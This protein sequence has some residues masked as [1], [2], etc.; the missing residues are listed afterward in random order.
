MKTVLLTF[1]AALCCGCSGL[2]GSDTFT[3]YRNSVVDANMRLHVASFD[4]A[5]G[6]AYNRENCEVAKQLFKAQPDVKTK[7]WCE[8][9]PFKK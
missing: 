6:E 2:A 8:K 7:F 4:S 5:D 3:L 9:G 1:A